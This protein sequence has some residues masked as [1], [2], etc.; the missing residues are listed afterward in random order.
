MRQR[1]YGTAVVLAIAATTLFLIAQPAHAGSCCGG[2]TAAALLMPKSA[3]AMLAASGE[4]E[5]YDGYF[6]RSG[7]Y[8]KD[9]PGSDLRQYR[10]NLGAAYRLAERWQASF[11]SG[12]VFNSNRYSSLVSNVGGPADSLLALTYETFDNIRCVW[13]VRQWKD[14]IPAVYLGAQV[15]LPTGI[16]PYDHVKS[17]FDITGRGFYRAEGK[18]VVEKTVYPFTLAVTALYGTHFTRPVNRDY[19]LYVEPYRKRLGDRSTATAALSYSYFTNSMASLTLT[20]NY[21]FL[22]EA[23]A[24]INGIVEKT[25]GF[26]RHLFGAA[27]AWAS[28]E[29]ELVYTLAYNPAIQT[30]GLQ[31]NFPATHLFSIG[32]NYVLR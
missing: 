15:V 14:M 4:I 30:A 3:K 19:G 12:Y 22:Y 5:K 13:R 21:V 25:S 28:P 17:S 11:A 2:G 8:L 27:L 10:F 1:I 32:V 29:R 24:T 31:S 23:D 9:P 20:F 6:D 7:R 26:Y 16:S 18:L